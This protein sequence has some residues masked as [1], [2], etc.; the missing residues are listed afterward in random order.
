MAADAGRTPWTLDEQLDELERTNPAVGK[1]RRQLDETI[2]RLVHYWPAPKAGWSKRG[3]N[4][5]G[6]D[7]K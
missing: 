3:E 5:F 7:E 2:D 6:R 1:A 4:P